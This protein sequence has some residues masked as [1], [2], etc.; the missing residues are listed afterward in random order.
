MALRPATH[1]RQS[2]ANSPTSESIHTLNTKALR[3]H[4]DRHNLVMTGKCQ[5]LVERLLRWHAASHQDSETNSREGDSESDPERDH[6]RTV[7]GSQDNSSSSDRGND[8]GQEDSLSKEAR[9]PD[10]DGHYTCGQ[11]P[12][13]WRRHHSHHRRD[14]GHASHHQQHHSYHQRDREPTRRLKHSPTPSPSQYR[15]RL[16]R[17]RSHSQLSRCSRSPHSPQHSRRT[18]HAQHSPSSSD[19]SLG[20]SSSSLLSNSSDTHSDTSSSVE[21]HHHR[22]QSKHHRNR[23]R[24]RHLPEDS[25]AADAVVSCV[26]PIPRHP[27]RNLKQGKYVDFT[28]LLLPMDPAWHVATEGEIQP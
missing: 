15:R 12:D 5:D 8:D 24:L 23:R 7:P 28:S 21:R 20:N 22:Y 3:L 26:P 2:S 16:T 13:P 9:S 19:S 18:H 14:G 27:R 25:W 10:K 11:H 17:K 6:T 4:L 1:N